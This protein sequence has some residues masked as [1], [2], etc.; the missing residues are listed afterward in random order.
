LLGQTQ[1]Y[2]GMH[3]LLLGSI[4]CDLVDTQLIII[5]ISLLLLLLLLIIS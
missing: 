3:A 4:P 2:A 5:I 1:K